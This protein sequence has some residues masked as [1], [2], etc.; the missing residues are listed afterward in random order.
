SRPV[1]G[2]IRECRAGPQYGPGRDGGSSRS[3]ASR[4]DRA[5]HLCGENRQERRAPNR[6]GGAD[7][8]PE[9][10]N[11]KRRDAGRDR[12]NRRPAPLI[13]RRAHYGSSGGQADYGSSANMNLSRIFIERP[14]MTALV[15]FAIL[16]FGIVGYRALPVAEL[17]SVD[18]PTIQVEAAVPGASPE[19]MASSV[20]TP[21]E[22]EFSTIQGIQSMSST[23]SL[24]STSITIQFALERNIDAAAQ[25]VQAA[26]S[27]AGGNLPATMP[28]PPSFR[29]VNPAQQPVLYLALSSTTLP[30]YTVDEYAETLLA[31]R[32]SM[33]SGVSQVIVYGAQKYAVR[34]QL[35]PDALAARN[36]GIDEVERA[37][38]AS[39]TNTPT[40]K[41][42]GDKQAFTI[43]SSGQLSDAAA[44]RPLI[45]AYRGGSPVRLD[46]LGHVIDSVENNKVIGWFNGVRGVILAV[47][48]QPGTNTIE[49]VDNIKKLLPVFRTEIPPAVNLTVAFDASDSIRGSINDVKFTLLLTICLVIMVIFLF[50]RNVSATLIP[51]VAVPLSIVGTFAVMYLLGYSLNN[52]SLMALTLSV[53]FVVDDAIVMLE[54]IVRFMEMGKTRMEAALLAS[55]EIGFTIL[56]MTISLVA[57]FIPVLFM[58]GI[59]GRL[60]HEFA[61][62]IAVAILISG[63]V[64][65]SLTPMLGS[66]FM[67]MD[68]GK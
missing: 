13:S 10:H 46:E 55:R 53:G 14:I 64:S 44:Y 22:R 3:G 33:V 31:Q 16:L 32:I 62:T 12:G 66:R 11:R 17:P 60:L 51:G 28:R 40:G 6:D 54:N 19:T 63:F 61:V 45:V 24:G 68:H 5:V 49:V 7:A 56:S 25:D 43:Q 52:L 42:Y 27:K 37:V 50:L 4:P 35:N 57:V 36:L 15:T 34:I 38:Q 39:N 58:G 47:Q 65:L 21:L 41:L 9:G 23:N 67:R 1:A 59:V 48:R 30:L 29:K 2:T 8:R 18:Y 26:I 20:A